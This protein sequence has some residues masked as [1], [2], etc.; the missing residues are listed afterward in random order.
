MNVKTNPI[1][2]RWIKALKEELGIQLVPRR[3]KRQRD[4][5]EF[6]FSNLLTAQ[7]SG[8]LNTL[9]NAEACGYWVIVRRRTTGKRN[10]Y[11]DHP[12]YQL[13]LSPV[14]HVKYHR[15]KL[16]AFDAAGFTPVSQNPARQQRSIA[17]VEADIAIC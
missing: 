6:I 16:L 7:L 3:E 5:V 8:R 4:Y 9:S 14:H 12:V 17:K 13:Y 10:F 2:Y 11:H 15:L 1:L